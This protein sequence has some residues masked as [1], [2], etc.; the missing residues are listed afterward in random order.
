MIS[1]LLE[2]FSLLPHNQRKKLYFLAILILVSSLF[3]MVSVS[4]IFP[5]MS[6]VSDPDF[7][8]SHQFL[9]NITA[10]FDGDLAKANLFVGS[11]IILLLF[12]SSLLTVVTVWIL[13]RVSFSAGLG[14]ATLLFGFYLKQEY[15]Y[16][17]NIN[18]SELIKRLTNETQRLAEAIILPSV[19]LLSKLTL[20]IL[21]IVMI[22]VIDPWIALI[23][24]LTF[25]S[26]YFLMYVFVRKYLQ[27]NAITISQLFG[28]RYRLINESLG[29]IKDL[30]IHQNYDYFS[31]RYK[32]SGIRLGAALGNNQ[33]I[34]A[35]PRSLI[36]FLAFGSVI[37][38]VL[39][40]SAN[41]QN[42]LSGL[43]PLLSLYAIAGIKLIPAFQAIYNNIARIKGSLASYHSIR[44]DLINSQQKQS[45]ANIPS[46]ESFKNIK[47]KNICFKFNHDE[48]YIIDNV[49]I[50]INNNQ[51]I[52]IIGNSGSG[53]STLM[54]IMLGLLRYTSGSLIIDEKHY[55]SFKSLNKI[56]A[57]VPQD[58]FI[59][60]GSVKNNIAFGVANKD[61]DYELLHECLHK[62]G[63]TDVI[64]QLPLG[65]DTN[66]KEKGVR[67]SGGQIQRIGIARALYYKPK[68]IF[69]DE[70][71]SAL[72]G[73]TEQQVMKSI[74]SISIDTTIII[75]AHRLNT[76]KKCDQI[77][78]L[79]DGRIEAIGDYEKVSKLPSFE[80]VSGM[81]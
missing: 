44:E 17:L 40:I 72:D 26:A 11:F 2:I 19:S 37:T 68:I 41:N 55:E 60:D 34:A 80:K 22:I 74:E 28:H 38:F 7:M 76:I 18:S 49:N 56:S 51:K 13:S 10:F 14:L 4:L 57:Y 54:N 6:I 59:C 5:F 3:E 29:S 48:N 23:G 69:F 73:K 20:I 16:H 47:L 79:A 35:F 64:Q 25:A 71:T 24:S 61:I 30:K 58:I 42:S 1:S 36:E 27:R 77:I 39:I 78:H 43:L 21:M 63:L 65:I 15:I 66:L 53:K 81:T 62:A 9:I 32:D 33:A 45:I 75:I 31:D 52:G 8:N 12:F 50:S 70:A 46:I 67:L